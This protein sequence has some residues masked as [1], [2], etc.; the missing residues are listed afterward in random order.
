VLSY[1]PAELLDCI[2]TGAKPIHVQ[3]IAPVAM[4]LQDVLV[5]NPELCRPFMDDIVVFLLESEFCLPLGRT[6]PAHAALSQLKQVV[7]LE[8]PSVSELIMA[9]MRQSGTG[10]HIEFFIR[11]MYRAW[12]VELELKL[13]CDLLSWLLNKA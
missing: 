1:D 7:I 10:F 2:F 8:A 11:E 13:L 12:P 5:R 9:V 3:L 6:R 4:C